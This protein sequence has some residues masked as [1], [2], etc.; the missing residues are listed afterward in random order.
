MYGQRKLSVIKGIFLS[1]GSSILNDISGKGTTSDGSDNNDDVENGQN[2]LSPALSSEN[3]NLNWQPP[4]ANNLIAAANAAGNQENSSLLTNVQQPVLPPAGTNANHIHEI[5]PQLQQR[6]DPFRL[7]TVHNE[8]ITAPATDL[9]PG[10][11]SISS[12][13][14]VPG[15]GTTQLNSR[16]GASKSRCRKGFLELRASL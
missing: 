11:H 8:Q 13:G 9:L 6:Q 7:N 12:H 14:N 2:N 4:T 3:Y 16:T 15:T 1:I 10:I 5:S